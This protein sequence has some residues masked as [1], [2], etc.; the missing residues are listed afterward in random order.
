MLNKTLVVATLCAAALVLLP[1]GGSAQC[2]VRHGLQNATIPKTDPI[3][4]ARP[5]FILASTKTNVDGT[6]E[7]PWD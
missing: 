7:T 5:A 6:E 3:I 2:S 1:S 4:L